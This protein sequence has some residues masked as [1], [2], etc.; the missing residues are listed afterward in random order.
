MAKITMVR[1]K[2]HLNRKWEGKLFYTEWLSKLC[3]KRW[4]DIYVLGSKNRLG[5]RIFIRNCQ[6]LQFKILLY[7]I[8][9]ELG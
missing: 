1:E 2:G 3:K 9:W 6:R 7:M 5:T 4:M 8:M